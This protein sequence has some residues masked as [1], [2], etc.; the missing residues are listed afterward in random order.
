MTQRAMTSLSELGHIEF[1]LENIVL[2]QRSSHGSKSIKKPHPQPSCA[3]RFVE[4]K[5]SDAVEAQGSEQAC[6]SPSASRVCSKVDIC[7]L[8]SRPVVSES[9]RRAASAAPTP[10]LRACSVERCQA[11]LGLASA[12]R[13][14]ASN[15]LGA[16]HTELGL[17]TIALP[18]RSAHRTAR[19]TS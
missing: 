12:R 16:G 4:I 14:V 6:E 8:G 9:P 13:D 17:E 18:Q 5:H 1:D 19:D 7:G 10:R 11:R 2:P 15:V 3:L